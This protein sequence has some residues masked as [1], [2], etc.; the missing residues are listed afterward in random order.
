MDNLDCTRSHD[1]LSECDF[2]G[3]GVTN[4]DH[5]EDVGVVCWPGAG[6]E[7]KPSLNYS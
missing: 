4:C 5:D 7:N 3:W 1:D 6:D 2:N